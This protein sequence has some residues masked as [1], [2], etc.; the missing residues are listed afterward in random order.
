[1]AIWFI[2]YVPNFLSAYTDSLRLMTYA[3]YDKSHLGS[4]LKAQPKTK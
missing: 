3:T 1:M 2:L 4:Q